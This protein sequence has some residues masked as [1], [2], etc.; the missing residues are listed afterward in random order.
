MYHIS[1]TWKATVEKPRPIEKKSILKIEIYYYL[2][3]GK[4]IQGAK[5]SGV[6]CI[7]VHLKLLT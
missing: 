7:N 3:W 4:K 1:Q 5:F 2:I 6:C